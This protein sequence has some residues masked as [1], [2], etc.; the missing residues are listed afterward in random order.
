MCLPSGK[1]EAVVLGEQPVG[2][3]RWWRDVKGWSNGRVEA[4]AEGSASKSWRAKRA[5]RRSLAIRCRSSD[6][7]YRVPR[8]STTRSGGKPPR[9]ARQR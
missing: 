9:S 1:Y 2:V 8:S 6:A 5:A 3:L 7:R 4:V